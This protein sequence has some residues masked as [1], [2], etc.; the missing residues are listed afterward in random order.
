MKP[1]SITHFERLLLA[2]SLLTIVNIF[3]HYGALRAFALAKGASPA[4]PLLRIL[5]AAGF[6]LV[7]R[8]CIGQMSSNIAR[9]LFA[10]VTLFSLVRAPVNFSKVMS[11]GPSYALLD[12]LCF[13]L[14]ALAAM[15][16]FRR[17]ASNWLKGAPTSAH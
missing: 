14:Q 13:G 1:R 9:W 3:A 15:V 8:I 5:V 4:G 17:D 11:I 7:F 10:A 2:S 12:V 16:L 6:Y